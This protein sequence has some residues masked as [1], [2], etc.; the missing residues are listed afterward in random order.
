[1][2]TS[3]AAFLRVPHSRSEE[4]QRERHNARQ[5]E[6]DREGQEGQLV[7]GAAAGGRG[8][9]MREGDDTVQGV[10]EARKWGRGGSRHEGVRQL[11]RRTRDSVTRQAQ[12]GMCVSPM[13][14]VATT[15]PAKY[16]IQAVDPHVRGTCIGCACPLLPAPTHSSM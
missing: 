13:A 5:E 4:Q 9:K 6:R 3:G 8:R 10:R 11:D 12:A 15:C 7:G 1:M 14:D 2:W 16:K